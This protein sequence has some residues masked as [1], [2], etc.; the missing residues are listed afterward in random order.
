MATQLKPVETGSAA[1]RPSLS[2]A[3]APHLD[4]FRKRSPQTEKDRMVSPESIALIREAGFVRALLPAALGGD[5]RDLVD[6]CDGVRTVTRACP[7]TGW[8]TGVLNVHQAAVGLFDRRVQQDI[9]KTGP[10]TVICSSGSP[11]MKA[12]LVEG[13]VKISGRGRWSSGCD[14]SE[15]ALIGLKVPDV[16][17]R[18]HPERD[19][20]SQMFFAH[21][22]EFTIDDTWYSMGQRGSGSKDLV[23]DNLFIAQHR[24]EANTDMNFGFT[25]GAGT[26]DSWIVQVPFALLF[27][28]FLPAIALGCADAMVEEYT[29][30]QRVRK[31]AYT[32]AQGILNPVG[33]ARLAESIHEL[34]A[35][36]VYYRHLL[37]EM[38]QLGERGERVSEAQ[39][40]DMSCRFPFI[41]DRALRIV[42]RL[43]EGAGASAIADFNPMQR[44]WR[45][46]HAARL[47]TGSDY[48]TAVQ[49]HG[50]FL[51]GLMPTPDL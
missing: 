28:T 25:R 36:S 39:F 9:L 10:D 20:K 43:F 37:N 13:G 34:D 24:L 27:A 47:H 12:E 1:Q 49:H 5:E 46:A 2:Q 19:Y 4:T 30:R 40:Y 48:D 42:N 38:Q 50:R 29:K 33:Y 41:T 23:F 21:R 44:Y 16:A 26:V 31:N 35:I 18:F 45:D 7:A 11:A 3:I 14:H 17:N 15:W 6:Y 51:M 8:V 22:S 32:N